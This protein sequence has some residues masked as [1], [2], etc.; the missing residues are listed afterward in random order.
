MNVGELLYID[1]KDLQ[2]L[3]EKNR[4]KI[5]ISKF[6]CF[7][8]IFSG[9]LFIVSNLLADYKNAYVP[10]NIIKT[11]CFLFGFLFVMWGGY[12]LMQN[13]K[14]KYNHEILYQE[15]K[16]LDKIAHKFSIVAIMDSFRQYP[17]CFL[18]YYDKRWDC[19]FFFNFPTKDDKEEDAKSIINNL[20]RE[21]QISP[22]KI[23]VECRGFEYQ[24]KFSV[25]DQVDKTYAHTFYFAK[26]DKFSKDQMR[27]EFTIDEKHFYW[28]TLDEMKADQKIQ[29]KNMDVVSFVEKML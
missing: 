23:N 22:S 11:I 13:V 18:L 28:M 27:K 7:E 9:V 19:K 17:K 8:T 12:L 4:N 5:G 15:I 20:S 14:S 6:E 16:S 26:I 24:A 29:E 3:L 10:Q 25:S 2:L 21:L 1:E